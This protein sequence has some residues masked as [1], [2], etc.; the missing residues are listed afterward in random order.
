MFKVGKAGVVLKSSQNINC[1]MWLRSFN[2][3]VYCISYF[4]SHFQSNNTPKD[5][6]ISDPTKANKTSYFGR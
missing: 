4:I 2:F 5:K 3:F 1:F 6:L